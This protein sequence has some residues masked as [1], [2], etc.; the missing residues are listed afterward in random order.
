M[1]A[2][3]PSDELRDLFRG[4]VEQVFFTQLGLCEPELTDY[5][6][7]L[8]AGFL[9]MD[10]ICRLQD[11]EAAATVDEIVQ[12]CVADELAGRDDVSDHAVSRL[13]NRYV[14]DFSLF[15][16]GMYPETL[17]ARRQGGVS[18]LHEFTLRGKQGYEIAS[19]LTRVGDQPTA[20]LLHGL[21]EQF[22]YCA[23]GLRLVRASWERDMRGENHN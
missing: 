1:H 6:A 19:T 17:R 2:L 23:D 20:D 9:H 7:R 22:E 14:G 18:R 11:P 3:N 8:L 16:T 10:A 4:T 13:L 21:S 12:R 5:L 15:W